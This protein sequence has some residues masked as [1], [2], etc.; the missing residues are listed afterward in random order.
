MQVIKFYPKLLL[1]LITLISFLAQSSIDAM[2]AG[3]TGFTTGNVNN[4]SCY[5]PVSEIA[6]SAQKISPEG[7]AWQRLLTSTG[8]PSF[9]NE[10]HSAVMDYEKRSKDQRNI[11]KLLSE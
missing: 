9:I 4:R 6:K 11:E 10:E 7:K 3:W 2:M 5:I 8:Q 1:E